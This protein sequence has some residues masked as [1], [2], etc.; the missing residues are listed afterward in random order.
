MTPSL[1]PTRPDT[2]APSESDMSLMSVDNPM[3]ASVEDNSPILPIPPTSTEPARPDAFTFLL[4]RPQ[5]GQTRPSRAKK[6]STST[7]KRRAS[8]SP[9]G[10]PTGISRS[11]RYAQI[12]K[13]KVK[14][15]T[16]IPTS[17][18][19][20]AFENKI[21]AV[22]KD[23]EITYQENYTG[24]D[25][26]CPKCQSRWPMPQSDPYKA[27]R[28]RRHYLSCS[29]KA[30]GKRGRTSTS[31]TTTQSGS[32]HSMNFFAS[33]GQTS[34]SSSRTPTI[35]NAARSNS[36]E[37]PTHPV[38]C[39]GITETIDP[40]VAT[41]L[42]RASAGSGGS[43]AVHVIAK[44]L[45]DQ[46]YSAL[47]AEQKK[48]VDLVHFHEKSWRIDYSTSTNAVFATACTGQALV[49]QTD[50]DSD[51]LSDQQKARLRLCEECTKILKDSRF[52]AAAKKPI[53]AI[54]NRKFINT[55]F[56][57]PK[58]VAIYAK[59]RG[60]EDILSGPKAKVSFLVAMIVRRP[61]TEMK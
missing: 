2:P 52:R 27:D 34:K 42:N 49:R 8:S 17:K 51:I 6:P 61:Y 23:A 14:A 56:V 21:R 41:Y 35:V 4:A 40:N 53:P 28:F 9:T 54:E 44:E 38:P 18:Q 11:S 20:E 45:F 46:T 15:G 3:D 39:T 30:K 19:L 58:V 10:G 29:G 43:R 60:L 57:N 16:Y 25:V 50:L 36:P 48:E 55:P 59:N 47:K 12:V 7:R 5:G 24:V 33:L 26:W 37:T 22:H 1:P 32:A 31:T 13:D